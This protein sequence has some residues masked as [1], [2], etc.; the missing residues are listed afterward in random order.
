[1]SLIS[2]TQRRKVAR[3]FNRCPIQCPIYTDSVIERLSD[4]FA[5][6]HALL[7]PDK[8]FWFRGHSNLEYRLA[9]TALRYSSVDD[10]NRALDLIADLKRFLEMKLP[11]PPAADDQLG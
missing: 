6:F 10:R 3:R 8:I 1:V 4:F 2:P 11:R 5:V 9:P 7:E